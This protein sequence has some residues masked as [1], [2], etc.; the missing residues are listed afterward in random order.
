MPKI[1]SYNFYQNKL[2]CKTCSKPIEKYIDCYD[3]QTNKL[4]IGCECHGKYAR[5]AISHLDLYTTLDRE[6]YIVVDFDE[7]EKPKDVVATNKSIL[8]LNPKRKLDL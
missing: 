8:D 6:G 7:P 3:P 2:I 1:I 4:I 5:L